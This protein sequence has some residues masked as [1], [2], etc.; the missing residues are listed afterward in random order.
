[1]SYYLKRIVLE[2]K[3]VP[4]DPNAGLLSTELPRCG[5]NP[6]TDTILL[7]IQLPIIFFVLTI[8]LEGHTHIYI[9]TVLEGEQD[10]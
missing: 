8:I 5:P 4:L 2:F 7:T 6:R 10:G 1:M 9:H 3:P